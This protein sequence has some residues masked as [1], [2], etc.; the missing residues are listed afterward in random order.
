MKH[1][2]GQLGYAFK[3]ALFMG[4]QENFDVFAASIGNRLSD[5]DDET[6][7]VVDFVKDFKLKMVEMG[8]TKSED[9]KSFSDRVIS[10][11]NMYLDKINVDVTKDN[12][13]QAEMMQARVADKAAKAESGTSRKN[14]YIYRSTPLRVL[15]GGAGGGFPTPLQPNTTILRKSS[16]VPVP[17][18]MTGGI[19]AVEPNA[20]PPS[21]R[22]IT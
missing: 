2:I 19:S 6:P 3:D 1:F 10:A 8:T 4:I 14:S 16:S 20:I 7:I 11:A 22:F 9:I 15:R 21:T 17:F 5:L 13:R 18:I 12:W